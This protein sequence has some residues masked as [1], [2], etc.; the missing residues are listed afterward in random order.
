MVSP[1]DIL[2]YSGQTIL[3]PCVAYFH[4]NSTAQVAISWMKDGAPVDT[5]SRITTRPSVQSDVGGVQFVRGVLEVC[6]VRVGDTGRYSCVLSDGGV[7]KDRGDFVLTV[8]AY[9]GEQKFFS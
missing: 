3:V 8:T 9:D 7:E 2:L 6:D 4:G 5:D 1:E